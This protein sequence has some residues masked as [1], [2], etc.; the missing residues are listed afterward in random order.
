MKNLVAVLII[1]MAL[2]GCSTSAKKQ[3]AENYNYLM[4][5]DLNPPEHFLKVKGK[6]AFNPLE[7]GIDSITFL[8][9]KQLEVKAL[10]GGNVKSYSFV[11]DKPSPYPLTADAGTLT[12]Y[13]ER[14]LQ[15]GERFQIDFEYEGKLTEH[16][17]PISEISKEWVELGRACPWFPYSPQYPRFTYSLDVGINP[18]YPLVGMGLFEKKGDRW[19]VIQNETANDMLIAAATSLKTMDRTEGDNYVAIHYKVQWTAPLEKILNDGL[20]ILDKYQNWFDSDQTRRASILIAPREIG[21]AYTRTKFIVYQLMEKEPDYIAHYFM[22]MSNGFARIWWRNA[23]SDSWEDW[24]NES[25]AVY[26]TLMAVRERYGQ[27]KFDELINQKRGFIS[28]LDLP[29]LAGFELGGPLIAPMLYNKG[30][31]ILNELEVRIGN[32]RFMNLLKTVAGRKVAS[33]AEFMSL[34]EE[35]EGKD[36]RDKLAR[37]IYG[38]KK[39]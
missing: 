2:N 4:T 26:S 16:T 7:N 6:L 22:G 30:P 35:L 29:P 24:L 15:K 21:G 14:P 12:I 33:T 25:F 28:R 32:P 20:W 17:K 23:P 5:A 3:S 8:L 1:G 31:L 19:S 9:H 36:A 27:G 11:V 13:F 18:E 10:S 34:V 38:E 39:P 37:S